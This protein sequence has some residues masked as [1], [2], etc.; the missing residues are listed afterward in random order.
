MTRRTK[1][2]SVETATV[3]LLTCSVGPT[4]VGS[5]RPKVQLV[6]YSL[7]ASFLHGYSVVCA[8]LTLR[9]EKGWANVLAPLH[10]IPC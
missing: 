1:C 5:A 9:V 10:N 2:P 7:V 8:T 3:H 4:A 6:C